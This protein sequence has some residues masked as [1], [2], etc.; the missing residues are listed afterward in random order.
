MVRLTVNGAVH[1]IDADPSAL[2]LQVLRG[3]IGLSGPKYGCGLGQ[4]GACL[5]LVDGKAARSCVLPL[6]AIL[7]KEVTTLEGLAVCGRLHAVQQAFI[8][9]EGTQCGYC[10]NGMIMRTVALL[11][12]MP[13]PTEPQIREALRHN[14]CRCGAH[15]EILASVRRAVALTAQPSLTTHPSLTTQPLP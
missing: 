8:E 3:M 7:D 12:V 4:C 11:R 1:E 5:V 9:A 6:A 10:L 2:L 14:L 15:E 13:R